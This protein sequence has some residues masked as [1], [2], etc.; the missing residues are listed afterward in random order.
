MLMGRVLALL[1]MVVLAAPASAAETCIV[2]VNALDITVDPAAFATPGV[3]ATRR[4]RLLNWPSHLWNKALG[5]PNDCPGDTQLVFLTNLFD[6]PDSDGYCLLDGGSDVGFLLVP[7]DRNFRNR[8]VQTT[9]DRVV[10]AADGLAEVTASA[11]RLVNGPPSPQ[12][13]TLQHATGALLLTGPRAVLRQNLGAAAATVVGAAMSSPAAIAAT[14]LTVVGVGGA[15][16]V[17]SR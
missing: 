3:T 7:G 13:D 16:F 14:S 11:T 10:A 8:C 6:L 1:S 5:N 2:K 9:C 17:C 15:V 4:E 12:L